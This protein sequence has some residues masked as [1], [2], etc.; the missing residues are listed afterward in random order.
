MPGEALKV[1]DPRFQDNR[2]MKMVRFLAI[3]TGRLSPQEN[4]P[5]IH[6]SWRLSR[7]Q[8]LI[9]LEYPVQMYYKILAHFQAQPLVHL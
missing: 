2:R 3:S 4:I 5:G 1:A 6:F 8:S 7:P 9:K